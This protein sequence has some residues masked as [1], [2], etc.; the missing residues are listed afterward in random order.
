MKTKNKYTITKKVVSTRYMRIPILFRLNN[1]LMGHD[2]SK[3]SVIMQ[4]ACV[5]CANKTWPSI[6]CSLFTEVKRGP[7]VFKYPKDSSLIPNKVPYLLIG[8]GTASFSAFRAI[9]SADPTAK[10]CII[11]YV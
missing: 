3:H 11:E 4:Y 2:K 7:I 8:G 9:K 10:V 6:T 5:L 1:V